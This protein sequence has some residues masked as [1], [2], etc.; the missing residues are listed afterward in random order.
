MRLSPEEKRGIIE[1]VYSIDPQCRIYLFG[2]R[3][4][5]NLSGGDIDLLL[6]SEKIDFSLK[7]S[8]LVEIKKLIGEQKIDLLVKT[9]KSAAEDPF[10]RSIKDTAI[11]LK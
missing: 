4:N 7:I 5:P 3:A 8:I 11:E 6:I 9:Q 2:S 10:V 1:A